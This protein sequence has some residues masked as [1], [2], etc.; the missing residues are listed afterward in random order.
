MVPIAPLPK[1]IATVSLSGTPAEKLEAAAA[2]GFDGVEIFENDLLTYEG[3][4]EEVRYLAETL[5]L[6]ISCFQPFRD[7]EAMPEPQ[8]SR[9]LDRDF[10]FSTGTALGDP[11]LDGADPGQSD[12]EP[13]RCRPTAS[14]YLRKPRDD[15]RPV[16]HD[17]LGRWRAA[18]GDGHQRHPTCNGNDDRPR[19]SLPADPVKL[20]PAYALSSA[21]RR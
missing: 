11:R 7:F 1:S 14:E 3:S 2:I 12:G 5:G 15:D 19:S 20:L 8:R 21:F 6:T 17:F 18:H 13:G 4:P 9:N 10:R 16:S